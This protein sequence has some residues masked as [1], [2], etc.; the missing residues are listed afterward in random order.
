MPPVVVVQAV[1][2]DGV[3]GYLVGDGAEGGQD[4]AAP[5]DDAGVGLLDD[6][7]RYLVAQCVP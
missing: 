2:R 1:G 3:D 4:A 6:R 5:D 7:Q